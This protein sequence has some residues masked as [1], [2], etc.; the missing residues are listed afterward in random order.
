MVDARNA[1][2]TNVSEADRQIALSLFGVTLHVLSRGDSFDLVLRVPSESG[3]GRKARG[4]PEL[5]RPSRSGQAFQ[6]A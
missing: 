3:I 4:R 5:S 1:T 2:H 6:H